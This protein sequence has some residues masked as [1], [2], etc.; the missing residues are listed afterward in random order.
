MH[1]NETY[2]TLADRSKKKM[3]IY[4]TLDNPCRKSIYLS[5]GREPRLALC[6]AAREEHFGN[7]ERDCA[8][9]WRPGG[10][11]GGSAWF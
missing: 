7:N 1:Q 11:S 10:R 9:I 2:F 5:E 3:N 6:C 4:I 8:R